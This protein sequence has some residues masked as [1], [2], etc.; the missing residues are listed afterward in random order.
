[1][2]S[3]HRLVSKRR[4][5]TH[6]DKYIFKHR[7]APGRRRH[8]RVETRQG[9]WVYWGCERLEDTSA[10]RDVSLG[11]LF[12][13]TQEALAVGRRS[14]L[15]FLSRKARSGPPVSPTFPGPI[16]L[17]AIAIKCHNEAGNHGN[18]CVS[19]ESA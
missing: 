4:T 17:A 6:P 12:V 11:G 16:S 10:A 2:A 18:R 19:R 7:I 1:M 15:T 13:A 9:V 8:R 5:D 14:G 3:F